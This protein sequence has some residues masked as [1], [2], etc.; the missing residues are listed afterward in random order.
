MTINE[1][2]GRIDALRPNKYTKEEK[3]AWLSH[4]DGMIIAQLINNY[5]DGDDIYFYGYDSDTDGE[6]ELI[7]P[8]PWDNLYILWLE[9]Q[10]DYANSDYEHYNNSVKMYNEAYEAYA[11]HYHRTHLPR[12]VHM[13]Y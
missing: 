1:A 11:R 3:I 6:T 5:E 4:L 9:S 10:I 13:K 12:T 8:S 7:V 2:L